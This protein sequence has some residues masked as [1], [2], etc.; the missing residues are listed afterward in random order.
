MLRKL[1]SDS[2]LKWLQLF[3]LLLFVVGLFWVFWR[4]SEHE[5]SKRPPY[6]TFNYPKQDFNYSFGDTS[7]YIE[8]AIQPLWIPVSLITQVIKHD[9]ILADSLRAR[10]KVL[11]FFP[12]YDSGEIIKS[13]GEKKL[14]GAVV[15][16]M[17][18]LLAAV[19][20]DIQVVSIIQQGFTSVVS[21]HYSQLEDLKG[22]RIG[23]VKNTNAHYGLLS[24][25]SGRGIEEDELE[26]VPMNITDLTESLYNNEIDAFTAWEPIP[27]MALHHNSDQK[28]VNRSLSMGF[29][30]F[31][32]DFYKNNRDE[33][34]LIVAAEIRAFNWLQSS[35]SNLLEA[36]EWLLN[37]STGF[38]E[39]D[40][41][42]LTNYQ[43][44]TLAKKDII[45][46]VWLPMI[47]EQLL[48]STG[49]L[50]REFLF[51]QQEK[52]I[53][54]SVSWQRLKMSFNLHLASD[55]QNNPK[56]Y[57]LNEFDYETALPSLTKQPSHD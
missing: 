27:G 2:V 46:Q 28:V 33:V 51:L 15:G 48:D 21:S 35:R 47:H 26:L 57:R 50:G 4:L 39:K 32:N 56:K 6:D 36:V 44:S 9:R 19:K 3:L 38:I 34:E 16:D 13:M 20:N 1:F 55:L 25:L 24:S 41:M 37:S 8:I 29:L 31:S 18:V 30:F 43:L 22:K 49:F 45:G 42:N 23:Y 10:G 40:Y 54:D 5:S 11:K 17:P 12:Y 52:Y 14:E 7:L 53:P